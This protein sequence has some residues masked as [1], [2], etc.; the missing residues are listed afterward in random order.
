[1][2]LIVEGLQHILVATILRLLGLGSFSFLSSITI[3]IL[4]SFLIHVI[5][6]L[7]AQTSY[8]FLCDLDNQVAK[9]V[10]LFWECDNSLYFLWY[11]L[12]FIIHLFKSNGEFCL[13]LDVF[14][15]SGRSEIVNGWSI[16]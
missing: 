3:S 4:P 8:N 15:Y 12:P 5:H 2:V 16:F 9:N 6:V 11:L 10:T 13:C 7:H 1:M 14:V